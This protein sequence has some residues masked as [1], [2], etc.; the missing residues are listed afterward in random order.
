MKTSSTKRSY[1][2]SPKLP[3][4]RFIYSNNGYEPEEEA[5]LRWMGN[6]MPTLASEE[7][8]RR[9]EGR[10]IR[11]DCK[12][13]R[14]WPDAPGQLPGSLHRPVPRRAEAGAKLRSSAGAKLR[15]SAGAKLRSS[16]GAKLR[17]SAGAKLRSSAG[18]KLRSSA[19]AKL[20]SSAG[21]KR[22]YQAPITLCTHSH[23][24]T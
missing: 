6:N 17:S 4:S 9:R 18:A 22:I 23:P 1:Q 7:G 10:R 5:L 19:G 13:R 24:K 8:Y 11:P 2:A 14:R 21:A 12:V 16:A 3:T 15:S 20:R